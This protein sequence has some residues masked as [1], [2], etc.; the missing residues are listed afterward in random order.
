MAEWK[1]V[2]VQGADITV[3]SITLGSTAVT[4]TAAE[5]NLLDGVSGLVQADFTK[6]AAVDA[7]AAE[8]NVLDGVTAGTAAASK[9]V[10]LDSNKDLGT[11]RDISGSAALFSGTVTANAFAGDGSNL[12]GVAAGSLDIDNFSELDAAPHATQDE[13]LVSDNGTEKRVSMTNVAN[14]AFALI[15]G[16]ATVAAGGALTI[17]ADSVEGTML[18]TNAA[19]TTTIEVSSDS[20][21]VLKVPNDL[22]VDNATIALNSGTTYNG[23][24]AVTISV[25]DGGIDADALAAG[26]AG[27]GL[28]GGGGSA[29]AVGAGSGITVAANDVAVTAA[30][31]AITSLINSSLTKIGTAADQEYVDFSTSNEVNV[32]INDTE[33][34]S[35]TATGVD[36]TG[37]ATVSSDL[38]VSGN[39]TVAGTTTEVQTANLSVEDK[40]ILLNSG[41]STAT[42]E[43]GIIFGGSGGTA[44]TGSALIWNGDY[45]S[46]DGRAAIAHTVAGS[47]TTATVAYYVGGVFDGNSSDA[48]TAKADHRGNIRV[49]SS[50]DIYIYV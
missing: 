9:A 34:L 26:V 45:N 5:L 15:S 23:S 30:Q 29:L 14:G 39:L 2:L 4:S 6:L 20:L 35:V 37:N 31:T 1:K 32:K 3:N 17:A 49:D 25:K 22:T 40:F 42:D 33:R 28:T 36:I 16:D 43:S 8:I 27:N 24:G 21:S 18:N 44:L 7:S 11:I 12:T 46:N 47:S 13:F 41:S 48:A 10:V 19:D 50:D 38:T